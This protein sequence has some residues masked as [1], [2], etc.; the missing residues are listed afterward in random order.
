[1]KKRRSRRRRSRRR[2][3]YRR[4]SHKKRRRRR[5]SRKRRRGGVGFRNSAPLK[6]VKKPYDCPCT[7]E[8]R[9]IRDLRKQL[10]PQIPDTPGTPPPERNPFHEDYEGSPLT[11]AHPRPRHRL[12]PASGRRLWS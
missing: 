8:K 12:T 7:E 5:R 6:S 3:S 11:P 2:R 9:I 1:M 10:E 4:R